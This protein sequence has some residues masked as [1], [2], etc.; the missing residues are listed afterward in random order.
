L[1]RF[2]AD[3]LAIP[4]NSLHT[5]EAILGRVPS[6]GWANESGDVPHN[7]IGRADLHPALFSDLDGMPA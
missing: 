3:I 5:I 6:S 2:H 7:N 1:L 4:G